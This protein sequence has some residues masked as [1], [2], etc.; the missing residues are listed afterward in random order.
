MKQVLNSTSN[1][2]PNNQSQKSLLFKSPQ[3]HPN[4]KNNNNNKNPIFIFQSLNLEITKPTE[5]ISDQTK[6][7]YKEEDKNRNGERRGLFL[8]TGYSG[9]FKSANIGL[10]LI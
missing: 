7:K 10:F 9:G 8:N 2:R 6:N 4:I 5:E 3:Q 1:P